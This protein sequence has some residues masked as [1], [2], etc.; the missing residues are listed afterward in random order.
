MIC[1]LNNNVRYQGEVYHVQTEDGGTNDPVISTVIF[2]EGRVIASKKT[3][4]AD[5][6][7][8]ERLEMVVKDL[9]NEQHLHVLKI[10]QAKLFRK[11]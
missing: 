10:L 9:M 11:V 8:F 5:I 6:I 1:G 3:N 2:K 4:Y 7:K